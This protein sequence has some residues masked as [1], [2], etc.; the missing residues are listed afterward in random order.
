M[1]KKKLKKLPKCAQKDILDALKKSTSADLLMRHNN[2]KDHDDFYV[3]LPIKCKKFHFDNSY[4][5]QFKLEY[6]HTDSGIKETSIVKFVARDDQKHTGTG[7]LVFE[8]VQV[9]ERSFNTAFLN[10]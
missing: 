5:N 7:N 2:L 4:S 1:H 10:K 3:P 6:L 9:L 8:L